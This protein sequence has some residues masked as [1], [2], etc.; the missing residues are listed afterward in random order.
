M[1]HRPICAFAQFSVLHLQCYI[2]RSYHL[3]CSD[4]L[5]SNIHARMHV[6]YGSRAISAQPSPLSFLPF[7]QPIS[8]L[9]DH[10]VV[11]AKQASTALPTLPSCARTTSTITSLSRLGN[12]PCRVLSKFNISIQTPTFQRICFFQEITENLLNNQPQLPRPSLPSLLRLHTGP[13]QR[14]PL[15]ARL[16]A[17]V[18]SRGRLRVAWVGACG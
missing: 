10:V 13:F 12:I 17:F 16:C 7:H 9:M 8:T 6:R 2:A 18:L 14:L 15:R 5:P 4:F 11:N 3:V 1:I